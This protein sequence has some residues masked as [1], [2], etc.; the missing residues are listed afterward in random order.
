MGGRACPYLLSPSAT[1]FCRQKIARYRQ[2]V[3]EV[4]QAA[5][6]SFVC[7]VVA[8]LKLVIPV[9][10]RGST[11]VDF[12]RGRRQRNQPSSHPVSTTFGQVSEVPAGSSRTHVPRRSQ[13]LQAPDPFAHH[14]Y[15]RWMWRIARTY[16]TALPPSRYGAYCARKAVVRIFAHPALKCQELICRLSCWA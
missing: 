4:L 10:I 2:V 6:V 8:V 7:G 16:V 5:R 12:H 9:C 15:Q 11:C 13:L 3:E 14:H 1:G